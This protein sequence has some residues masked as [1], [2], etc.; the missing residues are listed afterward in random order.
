MDD[1]C[2]KCLATLEGNCTV[3]IINECHTYKSLS[4][5]NEDLNYWKDNY[6]TLLDAHTYSFKEHDAAI[7]RAEKLQKE[8]DVIRNGENK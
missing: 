5:L 2:K 3:S 6:Q 4:V 7:A 8:L 1:I